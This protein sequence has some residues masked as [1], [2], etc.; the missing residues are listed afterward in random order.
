MKIS[1]ILV[2]LMVDYSILLKPNEFCTKKI[3]HKCHHSNFEHNCINYC[4]NNKTNCNSLKEYSQSTQ[5]FKNTLNDHLKIIRYRSFLNSID[6]CENK[7]YKWD[8]NDLCLNKKK[9]IVRKRIPL[10]ASDSY[11]EKITICNCKSGFT[12]CTQ[13]FCAKTQEACEHFQK[14]IAYHSKHLSKLKNC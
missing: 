4:T 7:I 14:H 8:S 9:C 6:S 1:I 2:L 13:N 3:D 12:K 10:R 5:K 11:I